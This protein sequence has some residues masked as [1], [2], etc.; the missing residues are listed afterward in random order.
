MKLQILHAPTVSLYACIP[1]SFKLG[2]HIPLCVT[3]AITKFFFVT[4]SR[5]L[6][7]PLILR[8]FAIKSCYGLTER[9]QTLSQLW[10]SIDHIGYDL[11]IPRCLLLET[12]CFQI[13]SIDFSSFSPTHCRGLPSINRRLW[14][15]IVLMFVRFI[16]LLLMISDLIDLP[17]PTII[18]LCHE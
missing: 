13:T 2:L 11:L 16:T 10:S 9:T 7:P 1:A 5:L 18:S 8:L 6:G 17:M 14:I 12:N 3:V 15:A 4:P